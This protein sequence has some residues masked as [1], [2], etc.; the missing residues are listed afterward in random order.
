M[1]GTTPLNDRVNYRNEDTVIYFDIL[2]A[3]FLNEN[4]TL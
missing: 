3:Q 4:K 1:D 2:L